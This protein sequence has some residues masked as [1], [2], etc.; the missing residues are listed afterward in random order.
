[1]L[2]SSISKYFMKKAPNLAQL[3]FLTWRTNL[4]MEA[5]PEIEVMD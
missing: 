3:Y 2:L 1:M 5:C 4:D